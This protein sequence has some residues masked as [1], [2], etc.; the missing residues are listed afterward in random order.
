MHINILVIH[1]KETPWQ[2]C[3]HKYHASNS[4]T[5]T[6]SEPAWTWYIAESFPTLKE[7]TAG[8]TY[9]SFELPKEDINWDEV[10][11]AKSETHLTGIL[12][13]RTSVL[14]I[15]DSDFVKSALEQLPSNTVLSRINICTKE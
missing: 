2:E 7:D 5:N 10:W 15:Q 9:I 12:D 3:L 4:T 8:H 14:Q 1:D 6:H 11:N 13:S